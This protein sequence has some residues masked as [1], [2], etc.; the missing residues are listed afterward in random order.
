MYRCHHQDSGDCCYFWREKAENGLPTQGMSGAF[1]R[2]SLV[3]VR[4]LGFRC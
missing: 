4:C 3:L 1:A 2:A